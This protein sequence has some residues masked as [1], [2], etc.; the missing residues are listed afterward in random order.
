MDGYWGQIFGF[1][2]E[3]HLLLFTHTFV[4]LLPTPAHSQK[5]ECGS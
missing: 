3:Q 5:V 1:V 4:V 2:G